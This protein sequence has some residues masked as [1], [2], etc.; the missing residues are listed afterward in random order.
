MLYLDADFNPSTGGGG[1]TVIEAFVS[2]V[3]NPNTAEETIVDFARF[4]HLT[5]TYEI[6][7]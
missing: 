1:G 4:D 3:F 7:S 2:C 6:L 5:K